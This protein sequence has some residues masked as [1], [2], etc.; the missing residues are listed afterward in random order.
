MNTKEQNTN[1][2]HQFCHHS[3]HQLLKWSSWFLPLLVFSPLAGTAARSTCTSYNHNTSQDNCTCDHDLCEFGWTTCYT[4][5]LHLTTLFYTLELRLL[6]KAAV[7]I[8]EDVEHILDFLGGLWGEATQLEESF[9]AEGF[10]GWKHQ[11]NVAVKHNH[12][13]E[14]NKGR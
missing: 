6:N 11:T 7:I 10:R 2:P 3:H 13:Q 4:R 8:I 12:R 14:K 1:P 5:V 9:V